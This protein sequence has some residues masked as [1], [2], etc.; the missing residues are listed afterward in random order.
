MNKPD[1]RV[2]KTQDAIFKAFYELLHEKKY[3]KITIQEIIDRANVGRT[4]FYAHF[5]TKD[6][7][8]VSCIENIFESFNSQ[9]EGYTEE[10][11]ENHLIPIDKLFAHIKENEHMVRGIIMSESGDM[12]VERLKE[13]WG[14]R[15]ESN[16]AMYASAKRASKVP[17][18][19]LVNH[20][21]NTLVSLIRY[22][23]QTKIACTPQQMEEY[24][25]DLITPI[26]SSNSWHMQN[27]ESNKA[28]ILYLTFSSR[29]STI[30]LGREALGE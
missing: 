27:N 28:I 15:L 29:E 2:E 6:D 25:Y 20:I 5:P 3:T 24:F 11:N 26:F 14:M 23:L 12:L 19:I 7:L 16:L 4:T 8:L 13:R 10:G 22:W 30:Y 9:L 18:D 1:R 17:V 21:A